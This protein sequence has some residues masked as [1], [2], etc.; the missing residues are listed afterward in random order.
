M[1]I[2]NELIK[3]SIVR[4]IIVTGLIIAIGYYLYEKS[5]FIPTH[6]PFQFLVSGI[7]FPVYYLE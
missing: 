6:W 5:V 4:F 3:E 1:K 2:D 7:T